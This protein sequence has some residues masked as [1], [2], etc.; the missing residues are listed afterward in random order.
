[1]DLKEYIDGCKRTESSLLPL[2]KNI[3][4]LGLTNRMLHGIIGISTEMGE[5]V[6]AYK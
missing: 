5:I 3:T 6:E 2:G 4:D 1:M